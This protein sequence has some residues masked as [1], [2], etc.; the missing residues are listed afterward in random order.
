MNMEILLAFKEM[1]YGMT[2][3]I[4]SMR[5]ALLDSVPRLCVERARAYTQ[6]Y[7]ENEADPPIVRRAKALAKTLE[8][9]SIFIYKDELLVGNQASVPRGAPVFPEYSWDWLLE[10]MDSFQQRPGDV[11]L[12]DEESKTILREEVIPYW[13]GKTLYD[14]ALHLIP[15]LALE[16]QKIGV[17]SGRGN[18]TSGDG[19]IIVHFPKILQKG[20][21]GII[22]DAEWK[23]ALLEPGDPAMIK[24]RSFYEGALIA[25]RGMLCFIER[26]ARLAEQEAKTTVRPHRAR[27]LRAIARNLQALTAGPP[28][29]FR[30]AL[31]LIWF[32]HLVTQI[33]SNG[34]SFS[35]GRLDQQLASF[36]QRD[37]EAG[38]IT[39]EET[40]ELL[41]N[42]FVK[43]F[44]IN[45]VR[46]WAHTKFG[47]GYTTYQN[48]TIGGQDQGGRDA[49][50]E[51]TLSIL[52][53]VGGVR[54]TTPNLSARYHAASFHWY[55][56]ECARVIRLGFGMPAMKNDEII[57]PA[58]LD[59]GVPVED[60]R[61]Y[62]I[63]G[64]VEAAVPGKWGYRNTGMTFLNVLKVLELTLHGGRCPTYQVRLHPNRLPAECETFEEFYQEFSQQL[65]FYTR[66][67][68]MMDA[69]ADT[70]LEE[71]APDAF[72]SALVEDCL[73][74]GKSVKEGGAVYDMVSGPFSGLA[75][76]ANSLAAIRKLVYEDGELSWS[77][78]MT[79]L[80]EN[81]VGTTGATV[82]KTILEQVPQYGNDED[83]VDQLAG[84]VMN[85]YLIELA[86]Y[87][88]TRCGRGPIGG[89]YCGSTS[90]ISANVPLGMAVGATPD[91]RKAREPIAEGA[92]PY[93]GTEKKG[94]TAVLKSVSTLPT[95]KMI[96]Q[97]LNLKF[98]PAALSTDE[99][100]K[101]LVHLIVAFFRD[102]KGWHVQFNVVE[103]RT[104]REAQQNPEKYRD[105]IVRVAGYSALFIAL[106]P[107]TQEDIIRRT[108][109]AL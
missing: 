99:D 100:L 19:H 40:V 97:L 76:A 47:I 48:V 73:A 109:H 55:L 61:D 63:V 103:A 81:F 12:I 6:T 60:A 39:L 104:L 5:E 26:Y 4:R 54:L 31:Q 50:N 75:N 82:R 59:K 102:L 37:Q 86:Q 107:C 13:K 95:V 94:P 91:G 27:E 52:K 36:W 89:S 35:L 17:I 78:L 20:L 22:A 25:L 64:C 56:T 79:A 45:K 24:K 87:R 80:G 57:I 69:G 43:M 77:D 90:N 84:R 11:F 42:L 29:D 46:P 70:A 88:N 105:L 15:P 106:D 1:E 41:Q 14:R 32:V 85:S 51:L 9:M 71:M 66:C 53:A 10:E 67:E 23:L 18:V 101:R 21:R 8:T 38:T 74:R 16:A 30:Q 96:A 93:Y 68:V 7:R 62:A 83:Y 3:R 65:A 34:H 49:T 98:T 92:S 2:E 72:C 108:E 44:T 28:G 58:L 33:E